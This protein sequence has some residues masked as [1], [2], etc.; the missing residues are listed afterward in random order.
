[1]NY[2][3][4]IF[5]RILNMID[6]GFVL[7]LLMG[8]ASAVYVITA[9]KFLARSRERRKARQEE[10]RHKITKGLLNGSI[11]SFEDLVNVYKGVNGLGSDD[12]S[13]CFGLSKF[14]R[15]YISNIVA[16]DDL[17]Y[18]HARILKNKA[19]DFLHHI[20]KESPFV[21]L[22]PAERN[23]LIDIQRFIDVNDSQSALRKLES[24]AGLIEARQDGFDKLQA[25]NRWSIPLAM[26][27]LVFTII[28]GITS[29][30]KQ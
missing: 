8:I 1:M 4:I 26:I 29:L 11:E 16:L 27:G 13:Y 9:S 17:D 20:D 14:L 19:T 21:D 23:L 28:F 3:Y 18:E 12:K 10:Q 24:L 15:E 30:I 5:E 6:R 7:S 2:D 22:P 25:S